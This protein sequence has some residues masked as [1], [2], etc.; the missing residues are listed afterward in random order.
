MVRQFD[1]ISN[2]FYSIFGSISMYV[3][4]NCV[5]A[6]KTNFSFKI[7]SQKHTVTTSLFID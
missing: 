7:S 2:I 6:N 4:L 1:H 3:L 5:S